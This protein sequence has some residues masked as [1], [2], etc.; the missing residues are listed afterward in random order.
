MLGK[1]LFDACLSK[2]EALV[3]LLCSATG[4]ECSKMHTWKSPRAAVEPSPELLGALSTYRTSLGPLALPRGDFTCPFSCAAPAAASDTPGLHLQSPRGC[5]QCQPKC[6]PKCQPRCPQVSSGELR[7]P[8][9]S[10][11]VP[12]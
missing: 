1:C 2:W 7:C 12:R 11:G 3:K 8:Q 6:Q 4:A 9:V 5:R 10:S